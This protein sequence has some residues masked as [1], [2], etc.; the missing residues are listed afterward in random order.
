[1]NIIFDRLN[2]L[3]DKREIEANQ[4]G[5]EIEWVEQLLNKLQS[6]LWKWARVKWL[7][8]KKYKRTI[9]E[10]NQQIDL[11]KK[12]SAELKKA[13][14]DWKDENVIEKA[15]RWW[16]EV[17][18]LLLIVEQTG[19]ITGAM[20]TS[21]IARFI[22]NI[23][24]NPLN[25]S[26]DPVV[27]SVVVLVSWVVWGIL[28]HTAVHSVKK[29]HSPFSFKWLYEWGKEIKR[30]KDKGKIKRFTIQTWVVAL[31]TLIVP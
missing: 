14:E 12:Q 20:I 7:T 31:L 5:R 27:F 26:Y 22:P 30:I 19:W 13:I 6:V 1:M 28:W 16:N 11:L 8:R 15:Q 24:V 2:P 10:V 9:V 17:T 18:D 25:V 23:S 3:R 21:Y 29:W 4:L